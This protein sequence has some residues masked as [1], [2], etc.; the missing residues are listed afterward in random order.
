MVAEVF[1][2]SRPPTADPPGPLLPRVF[3]AT[4]VAA[5]PGVA[6]SHADW[7]SSF[8]TQSDYVREAKLLFTSTA[9]DEDQLTAI[10]VNP[11][12][13]ED[14]STYPPHL[15][16]ADIGDAVA[17]DGTDRR[18]IVHEQQPDGDDPNFRSDETTPDYS[19]E[20]EIVYSSDLPASANDE[21]RRLMLADSDGGNVRP[22]EYTRGTDDIDAEP[23]WSPDGS[24]IAFTRYESNGDGGH[25]DSGRGGDSRRG[26]ASRRRRGSSS[27]PADDRRGGGREPDLVPDGEHRAVAEAIFPEVDLAAASTPRPTAGHRSR[28]GWSTRTTERTGCRWLNN[29][30]LSPRGV[31]PRS[32]SA[33]AP[34]TGHPTAA[35]VVYQ[36]QDALRDRRPSPGPATRSDV[37]GQ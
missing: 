12:D 7:Y 1:F 19:P 25:L 30:H 22:L 5:L 10:R 11:D 36:D 21:G 15:M 13:P 3:N 29:P 20:G 34:R 4:P 35:Q 37:P 31:C 9:V 27:R 26:A 23:V 33:V 18:V 32:T 6:E 17:A 8:Q 28:C 16:E 24:Q 14:P 2:E